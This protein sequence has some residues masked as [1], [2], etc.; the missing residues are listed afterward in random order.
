MFKKWS[1]NETYSSYTGSFDVIGKLPAGLYDLG[2]TSRNEPLA[3]KVD[4]RPDAVISFENGPAPKLIKEVSRFWDSEAKYKKLGVA[5]KR[6]ILLYGPPGCGK[7]GI[8]SLCIEDTVK[9]NGLVFR[10]VGV[11]RFTNAIPYLKQVEGDR[12]VLAIIE[13]LDSVIEDDEEGVLEMLDGA[14]SVGQG[15]IYL[16]TTNYLSKI[17]S[18][19]KSR[20]SR[21][22]TLVEIGYPEDK[23]R[24]EYLLF[25]L[26]KNDGGSA[27]QLAKK[28]TDLTQGFS[29][30]AMKEL[31]ISVSIYGRDL[32]ES[33]EL[34]R[35]MVV[36]EEDGADGKD[37][38]EDNVYESSKC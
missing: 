18:R 14:S 22:D 33:S 29:L 21:I 15:I 24:Y 35:K 20:P 19:I 6:G 38:K 31:V 34:I 2:T 36:D 17:P 26:T 12:P 27:K 1:Y 32:N 37:S 11:G 4:I 5:H 8:I 28:Y 3:V 13:D 9:R 7:T 16:A 25:L 23:Q 30:A 10:V